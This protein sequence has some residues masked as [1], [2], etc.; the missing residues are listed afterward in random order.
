MC[1]HRD[2]ADAQFAANLFVQQA[3]HDQGHGEYEPTAPKHHWSNWYAAYIVARQQGRT[4]EKA[5]ADGAAH[6][7][8]ARQ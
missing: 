5:A 6:I 3:R 2:L 4:Q 1:L 7:E 8:S